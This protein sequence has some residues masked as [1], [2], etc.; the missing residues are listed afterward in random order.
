[1]CIVGYTWPVNAKFQVVTKK[2]LTVSFK[3]QGYQFVVREEEFYIHFILLS[4]FI[5]LLSPCKF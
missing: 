3:E 1:M 5:F 2:Q 4:A